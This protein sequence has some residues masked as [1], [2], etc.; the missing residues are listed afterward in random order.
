MILEGVISFST[1]TS[2]GTWAIMLPIVIPM[3]GLMG[4]HPG[5]AL[6]ATLG[7]GL[8]GDHASPISDSTIVATMAAG[9]D[10]ID[11][12]RTQLPYTLVLAGVSLA[13]YLVLGFVM[14]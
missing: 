11:H 10:H 12:V 2:F 9:T 3:V 7:G 4:L 8:F 5:L 13:F 14:M 1:G 6:A